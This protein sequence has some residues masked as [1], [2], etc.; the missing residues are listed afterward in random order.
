MHSIKLLWIRW[1]LHWEWQIWASNFQNLCRV[2]HRHQWA[3]VCEGFANVTVPRTSP[4]S[5]SQSGGSL[6]CQTCNSAISRRGTHETALEFSRRPAEF[7]E[8][9]ECLLGIPTGLQQDSCTQLRYPAAAELL[10]VGRGKEADQ[11]FPSKPQELIKNKAEVLPA[12]YISQDMSHIVGFHQENC[13]FNRTH[14]LTQFRAGKQL[15]S[16]LEKNLK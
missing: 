16:H 10:G 12:P 13:M 14:H 1:E 2:L 15:Y 9:G 8:S 5:S 7:R 3:C 6:L 4:S 11:C